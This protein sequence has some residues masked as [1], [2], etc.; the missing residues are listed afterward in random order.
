MNIVKNKIDPAKS[1]I[2]TVLLTS[3]ILTLVL[4][5]TDALKNG[6]VLIMFVPAITA[7]SFNLMYK[8]SFRLSFHTLFKKFNLRSLIFA[9]AFPIIVVGA[10][11]IFSVISGL[12]ELNQEKTS[13]FLTVD[14][15][16]TL[17]VIIILNSFTTSLGEELGWRGHLLP[18]LTEKY[19][20]FKG[21]LILGV[22]WSLYHIPALFLL[23][24]L[25]GLDNPLLVA[26][27]QGMSAFLANF[28]FTYC[29]FLSQSLIPVLFLHTTWNYINTQFLGNIYT[30]TQGMISGNI[31]V[32]NGEGI[33]GVA[34][35]GISALWLSRKILLSKDKSTV[36]VLW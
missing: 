27:I 3:W 19:S 20:R 5:F 6:F 30:N 26:L 33:L 17:V 21:S 13:L 36:T 34:F 8:K 1:Y 28:A 11:G 9:F 29:F 12:G 35:L 16:I 22:V 15:L 7:I 32:I 18:L 10:C 23:A 24:S 31:F 4:Y 2:F 14:N 25:T